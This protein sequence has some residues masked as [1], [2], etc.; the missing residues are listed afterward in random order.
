MSCEPLEQ[1][2]LLAAF[3]DTGSND[4][5][6]TAQVLYNDTSYTVNGRISTDAD[7]DFF[8]FYAEAG[9]SIVATARAK[10]NS[11]PLEYRQLDP[12]VAIYDPSG[13][14]KLLDVEGV[15]MDEVPDD[16]IYHF[17]QAEYV[18]TVTGFWTVA[19]TE[20]HDHFDL[21]DLEIGWLKTG[22]YEL[23]IQGVSKLEIEDT[24]VTAQYDVSGNGD[25]TFGTYLPQTK[26]LNEFTVDLGFKLPDALEI[27]YQFG[28][29]DAFSANRS[30]EQFLFTK[31]MGRLRPEHPS[32][33][34]KVVH[35]ATGSTLDTYSADLQFVKDL[36]YEL[37]F[38]GVKA[39][40]LRLI[41]KEI[42]EDSW[43]VKA[44]ITSFDFCGNFCDKYKSQELFLNAKLKTSTGYTNLKLTGQGD[45]KFIGTYGMNSLLD[46]N[47]KGKDYDFA[48]MGT[49]QTGDPAPFTKV[50]E[51]LVI[52]YP[53]WM[54]AFTMATASYSGGDYNITLNTSKWD[55]SVDPAKVDPFGLVKGKKSG[56][57]VDVGIQVIVSRD[58]DAPVEPEAKLKNASVTATLLGEQK[59][60]Y[61]LKDKLKVKSSLN[62]ETL[63]V[64]SMRMFNDPKSPILIADKFFPAFNETFKLPSYLKKFGKLG[65]DAKLSTAAQSGPL[66]AN[67]SMELGKVGN[68][69]E[70]KAGGTYVELMAS[71]TGSVTVGAGLSLL[72]VGGKGLVDVNVEGSLNVAIGAKVRFEAQGNLLKPTPQ[73]NQQNSGAT[74]GLSWKIRATGD[75]FFGLY[76]VF[77]HT[78]TSN[79]VSTYQLLGTYKSDVTSMIKNGTGVSS[80]GGSPS[81]IGPSSS[82]A[83]LS[84]INASGSPAS[85][86]AQAPPPLSVQ[87]TLRHLEIIPPSVNDVSIQVQSFADRANATAGLHRLDVVLV[88][89]SSEVHLGSFDPA[90]PTYQA[91]SHPLGF[92]APAQN[93]SFPI[94]PSMVD[95][96]EIYFLEFRYFQDG[97]AGGEVIEYEV[98]DVQLTIPQ[99]NYTLSSPLGSLDDS[100][101]T[102]GPETGQSPIGSLLLSNSSAVDLALA[103]AE[104]LGDGFE[105]LT[106]IDGPI[107]VAAGQ[108][109]ALDIRLL[110]ETKPANAIMRIESNAP[111]KETFEVA[112][113]YDSAAPVDATIPEILATNLRGSTWVAEIASLSVSAPFNAYGNLDQIE[114][115]FSED[116]DV[117]STDV[118]LI[119]ENGAALPTSAFLFAPATNTATWTLAGPLTAGRYVL[120]WVAPVHDLVGNPLGPVDPTEISIVPGDANNDGTSNFQD[121]VLVSNHFGQNSSGASEGDFNGDGITNFADFVILSNDFGTDQADLTQP[122]DSPVLNPI[123][124]QAIIEGAA[125]NLTATAS[126]ANLLDT[127]EF[128]L[129]EAPLGATIDQFSG[130]FAYTAP[131]GLGI[132]QYPV[133]IRVADNG[134]PVRW[135]EQSFLIVATPVNQP[136]LLDA[137]TAPPVEQGD[138]MLFRATA[139][140][141]NYPFDRQ[142][143]SL[144]A[145]PAGAQINSDTGM[146]SW[147]PGFD[148][149][150]GDVTFIVRVTDGLT[151]VM[152]DTRTFTAALTEFNLP[153]IIDP[154]AN[155]AG[156]EGDLIAFT[157]TATDP[158]V[159]TV[160]SYSLGDGAPTGAAI[161][162]ALGNFTWTPTEDQV[163]GNFL[164]TVVVTDNGVP[165]RSDDV[166]FSLRVEEVN[167]APLLGTI[168]AQ[169]IEAGQRLLFTATATD[170]DLPENNLTFSLDAGAPSGALIDPQTGETQWTPAFNDVGTFNVTVRVTDDGAVPLDDFE[171]IS[172]E[173]TPETQPPQISVI[174]TEAFRAPDVA[175]VASLAG[176]V[177]DVSLVTEFR[178]GFGATPVESYVDILA[179][180]DFKD[181][182]LLD[183]S[184]LVAI[185]GGPLGEGTHTLHFRAVDANGNAANFE[186]VFQLDLT[187]PTLTL[188]LDPAFDSA[189]LGDFQTHFDVVSI[190]GQTEP[191][192]LVRLDYDLPEAIADA[193]GVVRWN[194]IRLELGS[195]TFAAEV[196]DLAGNTIYQ[197]YMVTRITDEG[198]VGPD[199]Y[200]YQACVAAPTFSDISLTGNPVLIGANQNFIELGP[201]ELAGFDFS[202]YGVPVDKLFISSDGL[203][204]FDQ[205]FTGDY[206]GTW[207]GE[208]LVH[209]PVE[210]AIAPL[211]NKL[212]GGTVF[213]E[214]TGTPG[215]RQLIVQWD[216]ATVGWNFGT[217]TF[218]AVLS[219]ADH[220]IQFNYLDLDGSSSNDVLVDSTVG[221]KPPGTSLEPNLRLAYSSGRNEL[222]GTGLSTLIT[223][224]TP[225]SFAPMVTLGLANDNGED[226]FDGFSNDPTISGGVYDSNAIAVLL[227]GVDGTPL[228]EFTEILAGLQ[229]DGTF[230]LDTTQLEQI[231][232]GSLA[233]GAHSIR[234]IA[235]D[236][237]GN[238]TAFVTYDFVLDTVAPTAAT[239]RLAQAYN[240]DPPGDNQTTFPFVEL[241]GR[242]EP[243]AFVEITGFDYP[244]QAD[245]LG[246]F[247][248]YDV[249]LQF[250]Q[251][252]FTINVSDLAGNV[253]SSSASFER[254]SVAAPLGS[255]GLGNHSGD[256]DDDI[257][258]DDLSIEGQI[259]GASSISELRAG[260][261]ATLPASFFDILI[262]LPPDETF[263]QGTARVAQLNGAP[264]N[265]VY[266]NDEVVSR[267]GARELFA[268]LDRKDP[269]SRDQHER[270]ADDPMDVSG[271]GSVT[272]LDAL[273]VINHLSRIGRG[274]ESEQQTVSND[275]DINADGKVSV[276]DALVVINRLS[277]QSQPANQSIASPLSPS[278]VDALWSGSDEDDEESW[279]LVAELMS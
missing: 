248:F 200:G 115:V 46:V 55:L 189:P 235:E 253:T 21:P 58:L 259:I 98:H 85:A 141:G 238:R 61:S 7:V 269:N 175:A 165:S 65:I 258:T 190:V 64:I 3:T 77:D 43:P 105:L 125:V 182:F 92:A 33:K 45:G 28:G 20:S 210:G 37:E 263:V 227:A 122:N 279:G 261:D 120:E 270:L 173:V 144:D 164:I 124:N 250:G 95:S 160:F 74:L 109:V 239:L 245:R 151:P 158:N 19:V 116:V 217:A 215:T 71:A 59:S 110:D 201:T 76:E 86:G 254:L 102:F 249:P 113:V 81:S 260:F 193:Q 18:A 8:T 6:S 91:D 255:A 50:Q 48:L 191:F 240:S 275:Y 220:S 90:T 52:S 170:A 163:A 207:S 25:T 62:N 214:M 67:V 104:I 166:Q 219:E 162:P 101:L 103:S 27:K 127:L 100:A 17:H 11:G 139:S 129:V 83:E 84:S 108:A 72:S 87:G 192:A 176:S 213:W 1:R 267:D 82:V 41:G 199:P 42:N 29:L 167:V 89:L 157:A 228:V 51:L 208:H 56:V 23:T 24:A 39:D 251:N 155:Q 70:W 172:V 44:S 154:V 241:I 205:G 135:A 134:Q 231:N 197:E 203:I 138:Q 63:D 150:P 209:T 276:M 273:Q 94:D 243:E 80:G 121:F 246:N 147:A 233:D 2:T 49:L 114:V 244:I 264:L 179:E 216:N 196:V 221:I 145:A 132:G 99:T 230:L 226:P 234:V 26:L 10:Y 96:D 79:G 9:D 156:N 30:D 73:L 60:Q 34:V 277:R 222:V 22:Q 274:A 149:P 257:L 123:P 180:L 106:P 148:V 256:N 152:S 153:P 15:Y 211:W 195:R 262:D 112:L 75:A 14:L 118:R 185:N 187:P 206:G 35:T 252:D 178:A 5:V 4:S 130:A 128:S 184:R 223:L 88:G 57:T 247:K 47:P 186:Y 169:Q 225:D 146:I 183:E 38:D 236:S 218:Q 97:D 194:D 53:D 224:V 204:T 265:E 212:S 198:C 174:L 13:V 131:S 69:V 68:S 12:F 32:L 161:D 107:L 202:F 31:D 133:T 171:T 54:K 16:F 117:A 229:T 78:F 36:D 119:D 142:V 143:F 137:I 126:D 66:T 93:A 140:D 40:K 266:F 177:V 181:D 278:A 168:G 268:D 159:G 271:D 188:E 237:L 111:A 272:T 232:G 242:T 136:P